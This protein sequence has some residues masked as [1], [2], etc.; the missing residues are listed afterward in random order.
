[1][2]PLMPDIDLRE[3]RRAGY[4][5]ARPEV[6]ALVPRFASAILDLGCA[7]GALGAELKLRQQARVVGVE[8]DGGY[9]A[10]AAERLDHVVN[11][12]IEEALRGDLGRFDCIVAADVLEHLVDPW[13]ALRA[14]TALLDPG[15]SVVVSVP[16]VR[17]LETLLQLGFRGRWPR[18]DQGL[19]DRTHLRWFTL[20]DARELLEQAGVA[21]EHVEPRYFYGGWQLR[22]ARQLGRTPLAPFFTGQ[23]ILLARKPG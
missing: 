20:A 11:A 3:R 19:F 5:T 16:N 15:G 2:L 9:A 7:S 21:V 13:G 22:V 8:L 10:A 6:Q 17:S 14:A 23:Y 12:G 18:L 1:M 4:E